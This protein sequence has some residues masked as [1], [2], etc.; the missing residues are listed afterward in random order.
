MMLKRGAI[1]INLVNNA[2]HWRLGH[3]MNDIYKRVRLRYPN[4]FGGPLG[5][6]VE[7]RCLIIQQRKYRKASVWP[8]GT[9][10]GRTGWRWGEFRYREICFLRCQTPVLRGR[11]GAGEF[12]VPSAFGPC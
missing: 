11:R 9:A 10:C 5:K 6:P 8:P 12:A 3:Y 4:A 2:L 7:F 1:T